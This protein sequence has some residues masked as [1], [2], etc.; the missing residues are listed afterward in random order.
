MRIELAYGRYNLTVNLPD[1]ADVLT[2]RFLPGLP[3]ENA[4]LREA[5]RNP[6]GSPPL[7]ELVSARR[8]RRDRSHRHHPRHAE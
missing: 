2:P 5:L 4:A 3:D 7:I 6:I 1:N 8:S